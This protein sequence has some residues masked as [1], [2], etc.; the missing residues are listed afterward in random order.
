MPKNKTTRS[1]VKWEPAAF[2][3]WYEQLPIEKRVQAWKDLKRDQQKVYIEWKTFRA[4]AVASGLDIDPRSIG[5]CDPNETTPPLPDVRCL[6][7]GDVAYFELGEVTEEDLA[8][9]AS[10]AMK[11]RLKVYGGA[12]SQ[13]QPLVRIFLKKCR[14]RYTTNGRPLHLVLHFAVGRQS[15]FEPQLSAD[16]EKWRDRL[17]AR[18]RRSPFTSVWLYDDW[19]KEVLVRLDR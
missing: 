9:K 19:Q 11:N 8:Q 4:F 2:Y 12:V 14:N 18:I 17:I 6:L 15:P 10:L 16:L 1:Q 13:R 5:T 7:S 3:E